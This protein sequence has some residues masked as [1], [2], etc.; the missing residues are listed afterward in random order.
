MVISTSIQNILLVD[1]EPNIRLI[2][3]TSLHGLTDWM[4]TLAENGAQ[5][6]KSVQ[7]NKPD[8]IIL[9]M[10]MPD[11]DG[12]TTLFEIRKI[13]G[14]QAVPVIFMTAKVQAHELD[15]YLQMSAAGVISK[16]FD[17]MQF[18]DQVREI[19]TKFDAKQGEKS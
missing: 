10:M 8:L 1:D 18:P 19:L 2:A 17:P 15:S 13:E 16:P 9:D 4:V 6:I 12:P 5:A 14:M 11:M 3:Q 7:A